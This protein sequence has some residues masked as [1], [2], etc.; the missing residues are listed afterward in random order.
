MARLA[1]NERAG[2]GRPSLVSR[3]QEG[4]H[5]APAP[6]CA[7]TR[8][9]DRRTYKADADRGIVDTIHAR[10]TRTESLRTHGTRVRPAPRSCRVLLARSLGK[11]AGFNVFQGRTRACS[12]GWW[13][14]AGAGLF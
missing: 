13:L 6:P 1:T 11:L 5:A 8:Q 12:V 14:M 2:G 3:H 4:M 10:V 9:I 7:A